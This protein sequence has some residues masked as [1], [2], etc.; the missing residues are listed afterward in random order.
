MKSKS[1]RSFVLLIIVLLVLLSLSKKF[2]DSCCGRTI[3]FFASFWE[4]L[5]ERKSSFQSFI[6]QDAHKD[7]E[8]RRL[9]LNNRMLLQE[10]NEIQG[11]LEHELSLKEELIALKATEPLSPPIKKSVLTHLRDRSKLLQLQFE[12]V[13]A[14]VIF[15]SPALW[16]SSLWINVGEAENQALGRKVISKNSP[17][18]VG[19][20]IVGV[21]EYVGKQQSRVRLITDSGLTPSVRVKRVLGKETAYLAKGELQGSGNPLWRSRGSYLKGIGFNYEFADE[22]GPARDLRSDAII[23]VNDLL[24]TTGMDGIFPAGFQVALVT[25]IKPLDEGDYFYEIEAS[26][27]AGDLD[28]LHL[29]FVLPPLS[30]EPREESNE[31]LF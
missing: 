10:I 24:V 22:E 11:L 7:E 17:V 18:T 28:S 26:P 31:A 13:P 12:A 6:G 1:I 4:T 29:L 8:I 20:S 16:E 23:K 27:T 15:R 5:Y 25:K 21:I 19:D 30:N 3:A 14:R 2:A 9:Q